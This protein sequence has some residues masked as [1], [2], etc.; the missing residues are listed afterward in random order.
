MNTVAS[1]IKPDFTPK[2]KG[3]P[4]IS[5][6]DMETTFVKKLEFNSIKK[7]PFPEKIAQEYSEVKVNDTKFLTITRRRESNIS[8]DR[9]HKEIYIKSFFDNLS[10]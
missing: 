4:G 3:I 1:F 5:N 8:P 6:I 10:T 2:Y 7:V 9:N